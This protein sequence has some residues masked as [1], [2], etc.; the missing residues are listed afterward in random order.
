M[1]LAVHIDPWITAP[2]AVVVAVGLAWYYRCLGGSS[3]PASRRWIRRVSTVVMIAGLVPLVCG[4]S[5]FDSRDPASYLWSWVLVVALTAIVVA[6]AV[7]DALNTTRLARE[8]RHDQVI[9]AT[10][11]LRGY[12]TAAVD[13]TERS[14]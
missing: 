3:Y 8:A 2:A 4:L 10:A 13:E 11:L 12:H 9:E 7:L 1:M 14:T 6:C 5:L